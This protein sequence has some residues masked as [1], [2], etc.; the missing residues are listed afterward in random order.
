MDSG[1][2]LQRPEAQSWMPHNFSIIHTKKHPAPEPFLVPNL[3]FDLAKSEGC[4]SGYFADAN[5]ELSSATGAVEDG[6]A[7][8][9]S[10]ASSKN[11]K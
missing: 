4:I 5:G 2:W 11:V 1:E 3:G 8:A 7:E 10:C 9:A 6:H